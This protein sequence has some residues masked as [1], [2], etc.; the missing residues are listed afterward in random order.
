MDFWPL[1]PIKKQELGFQDIFDSL[2]ANKSA[3]Y[4]I[5]AFLDN[6]G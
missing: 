3:A 4:K 1:H 2:L 6:F 5:K